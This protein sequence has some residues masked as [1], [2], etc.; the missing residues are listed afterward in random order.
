MADSD[1]GVST[2][3]SRALCESC[4]RLGLDVTQLLAAAGLARSVVY[5]PDA[6]IEREQA[7]A[8]WGEAFARSGDPD[9]ALHAV[10]A[11]DFGAY[12]VLD[13][14]AANAPTLG[15]GLQRIAAY[16]HLVDAGTLLSAHEG[17]DSIKF[18]M[19]PADPSTTQPRPVVE[20]TL[21]AIVLRTRA[22]CGEAYPLQHVDVAYP[23]PESDAEHRRIFGCPVG[24]GRPVSELSLAP[25]VWARPVVGAQPA[26][27]EILEEHARQRSEQASTAVTIASQV[28]DLLAEELRGGEPTLKRIGKR[29]AMS[30]R[31]LQRRLKEHGSSF[32]ELLDAVRAEL[33]RAY[34]KEATVSIG[35]VGY[36]LGFDDQSSFS[37]AFKRWTGASPRAYRGRAERA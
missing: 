31:A 24:F 9:L 19:T 36:L 34:L 4:D 10:E 18:R 13:F 35:E 33:A 2:V 23:R 16:F 22:A 27:F 30:E 1:P 25:E 5:D 32:G 8:L 7:W 12:K 11:L 17:P 20:Y 21:A 37:R 29:L 15:E 14:L 6:R 28:R 26:L 3:S